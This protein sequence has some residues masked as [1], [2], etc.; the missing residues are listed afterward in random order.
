MGRRQWLGFSVGVVLT[1]F[2]GALAAIVLWLIRSGNIDLNGLIKET[3]GDA[4]LSRFQFLIFAFV[5]AMSPFCPT[6]LQ[7]GF[8]KVPNRIIGLLGICCGSCMISK[9]TA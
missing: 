5:I 8:P 7:K 9:W 4:S 3:N 2:V 1:V 6:A